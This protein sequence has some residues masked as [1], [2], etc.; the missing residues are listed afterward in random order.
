MHHGL[1]RWALIAAG[2]CLTILRVASAQGPP[3][4]T[5]T[6]PPFISPPPPPLPSVTPGPIVGGSLEM[7]ARD[8]GGTER[9]LPSENGVAAQLVINGNQAVP[10]TLQV[11]ANKAGSRLAV[12]CLDGGEIIAERLV[13]LPTGRV[14]FVF[15]AGP[16]PGLYRVLVQLPGEQHQLQFYV[17]DPN[18]PRRKPRSATTN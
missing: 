6:P 5:P 17:I 1:I 11:P 2:C 16:A 10:V 4:G 3:L 9:H 14:L 8:G 15:R 18:R 12:I 13:V 7:I